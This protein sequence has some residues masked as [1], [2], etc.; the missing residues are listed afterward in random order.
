MEKRIQVNSNSYTLRSAQ[1][2]SGGDEVN[3]SLS[4]H[5]DILPSNKILLTATMTVDKG[6]QYCGNEEQNVKVG[7]LPHVYHQ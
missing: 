3:Y 1:M 2:F 5:V 7:A 6:D 4:L